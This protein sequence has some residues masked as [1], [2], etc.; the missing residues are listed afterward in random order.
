MNLSLKRNSAHLPP[1]SISPVRSKCRL[2]SCPKLKAWRR[3]W[4]GWLRP[5]SK[6]LKRSSSSREVCLLKS[7]PTSDN[8]SHQWSTAATPTSSRVV[9][10]TM[11]HKLWPKRAPLLISPLLRGSTESNSKLAGLKPGRFCKA[12]RLRNSKS[13]TASLLPRPSLKKVSNSTKK[14]WTSL[15]N[16][17]RS[18]TTL[19]NPQLNLL[20]SKK[21]S[22]TWKAASSRMNTLTLT[23]PTRRLTSKKPVNLAPWRATVKTNPCF[24]LTWTLARTSELRESSSTR[25]TLLRV[26]P[27]SSPMSTASMMRWSPNSLPC[28]TT[29]LTVSSEELMRSSPTTQTCSPRNEDHPEVLPQFDLFYF[30]KISV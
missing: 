8:P 1:R 11:A 17:I 22:R 3:P 2:N 5:G 26:L 19:R 14:A 12:S 21:L 30:A 13:V 29:K 10:E 20:N 28:F 4:R 25:A 23:K 15:I 9:L 6:S 18:S 24:T 7:W 27:R 16:T